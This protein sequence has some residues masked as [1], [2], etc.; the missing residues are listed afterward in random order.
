MLKVYL[1][2]EGVGDGTGV[3]D[4]EGEGKGEGEGDGPPPEHAFSPLSLISEIRGLLS[5]AKLI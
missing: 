2:G 4:G 3:G 1:P 5:P